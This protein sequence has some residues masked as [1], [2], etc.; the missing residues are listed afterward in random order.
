MEARLKRPILE[1]RV[2][3]LRGHIEH[4]KRLEYEGTSP[5]AERE[6]ARAESELRELE[7]R[8]QSRG[9]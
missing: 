6:L 8:E 2:A 9:P 3:S 7:Q 1:F 5:L 4:L